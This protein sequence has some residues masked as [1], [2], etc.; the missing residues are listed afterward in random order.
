MELH[1]RLP[2]RTDADDDD[3]LKDSWNLIRYVTLPVVSV[4]KLVVLAIVL[5]GDASNVEGSVVCFTFCI[6]D[7]SVVMPGDVVG[8]LLPEKSFTLF[9]ICTLHV[10]IFG[11]YN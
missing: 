2:R 5:V 9:C 4:T 11:L 3:T 8:S 6:A 1:H 10:H 7:G